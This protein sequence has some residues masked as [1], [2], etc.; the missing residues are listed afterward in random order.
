MRLRLL[1]KTIRINPAARATKPCS[2]RSIGLSVDAMVDH[3][4]QEHDMSEEETELLLRFSRWMN[5]NSF[6][7][8]EVE[9][10]GSK[11]IAYYTDEAQ[12]WAV[13]LERMEEEWTA[14]EQGK[15]VDWSEW[16]SE[17]CVD[18]SSGQEGA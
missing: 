14:M 12:N 2:W 4:S 5:R 16:E 10:T 3:W 15:Q 11:L 6:W 1:E 17:F 9:D 7:L 13:P 8:G 18:G